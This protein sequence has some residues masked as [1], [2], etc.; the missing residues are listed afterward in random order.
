MNLAT[1]LC[2]LIRWTV[3]RR[4]S[5]YGGNERSS[6]E[7]S[8]IEHDQ[9]NEVPLFG[10]NYLAE[11]AI[12]QDDERPHVRALALPSGK[13]TLRTDDPDEWIV[14]GTIIEVRP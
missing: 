8:D 14:S 13:L 11:Q 12:G 5:R 6:V 7:A 9:P 4:T 2:A 1:A 3:R 10:F